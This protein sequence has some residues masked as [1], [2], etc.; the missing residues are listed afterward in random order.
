MSGLARFA[1]WVLIA[2]IRVYQYVISPLIGPSCRYYPTCSHYAAE[3]I[4]T[5]GPLKGGYL[6]VRRILS[7]HPFSAGGYDPVPPAPCCGGKS[8]A[9]HPDGGDAADGSL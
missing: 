9:K 2:P 1:G 3:A 4:E 8:S 5:H 6:A 7:C